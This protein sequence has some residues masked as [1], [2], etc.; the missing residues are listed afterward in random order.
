MRAVVC[1]EWACDAMDSRGNRG[2]TLST[3]FILEAALGH[4]EPSFLEELIAGHLQPVL[5]RLEAASA[6]QLED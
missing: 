2:G 4:A 1:G 6:G 5:I 3:H